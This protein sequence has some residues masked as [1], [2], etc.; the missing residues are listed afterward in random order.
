LAKLTKPGG[1]GA[2]TA[3]SLA[4]KQQLLIM[5]RAQRRAPQLTA[6]DHLILEACA[7]F[8]APKRLPKL[9]VILRPSLLGFHRALMKRKYHLLS[10][11]RKV[12]RVRSRNCW[13]SLKESRHSRRF[14]SL[15]QKLA[16]YRYS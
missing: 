14:R 2:V 6:W 7:L 15:Y 13:P 1:L 12:S 3:E 16:S 4:F 9:A 11:P 5:R 10:S 8:V